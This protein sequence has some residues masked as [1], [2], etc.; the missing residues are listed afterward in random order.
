M[1][2][3]T[4][5]PQV[6]KVVIAVTVIK[7]MPQFVDFFFFVSLRVLY[8]CVRVLHYVFSQEIFLTKGLNRGSAFVV[9]HCGKVLLDA[10]Q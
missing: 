2:R 3:E 4:P 7:V 1:W 5:A 6:K 8:Q 10:V 9:C